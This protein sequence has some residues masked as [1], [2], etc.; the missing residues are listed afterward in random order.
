[1]HIQTGRLAPDFRTMDVDGNPIQLSAYRG[2]KIL[3]NFHRNVGCPVCNLRF[4]QLQQQS[5]FFRTHNLMVLDVYES[6]AAHMRVYLE[7]TI[8]QSVMIPDP[9]QNLYNLYQVERSMSKLFK[10][11]LH[12]A[13]SK[14]KQGKGLFQ[15]SIKQDGNLNRIG[16][17]FLIDE[18][19]KVLIAHYG[20]YLGDHIPLERIKSLI[21]APLA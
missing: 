17:E 18:S 8:V 14:M 13:F 1:M 3:L 6:A 4:H 10:G 12:G 5:G 11:L 7:G 15:K 2:K 16:A 19:G 21:S 20:A 9:E